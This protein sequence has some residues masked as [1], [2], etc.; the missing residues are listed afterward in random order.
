MTTYCV[1][2]STSEKDINISELSLC[3]INIM[4]NKSIISEY[5]DITI[6]LLEEIYN[7]EIWISNL[8]LPSET[9]SED[10]IIHLYKK[11]GIEYTLNVLDGVFS[12]IL[13]DYYYENI[14][15]NIYIVKD[16]FGIVPFYCFT[17]NKTIL[18]TSSK[19]MPETYT[20]HLLYPGSY[21][22]Y[23]LGYKVNAE[24]VVSSIK[25]RA[26]FVVPNS[27]ITSPIDNY[28]ISLYHLSTCMKS[29]I[30]KMGSNAITDRIA[31]VVLEKLFSQIDCSLD[32]QHDIDIYD[33]V[34]KTLIHFSPIHFFTDPTTCDCIFHYDYKTRNKLKSASFES[35]K[36]YPFYDKAFVQ[37]YFSIPLHMRYNFHKQLFSMDTI[38]SL[39]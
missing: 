37:L 6:F 20:E 9:T 24:W 5:P 17:N 7:I 13:F 30:L 31:D 4:M 1:L 16:P 35:D 8:Q 39:L 12:F 3:G 27:V 18:F 34:N 36:K 21:T 25:N 26:Y 22:I 11:Y 15:S 23:E 10:V 2:N 28:S 19:K 29:V 32:K 14:I 33:E 38:N